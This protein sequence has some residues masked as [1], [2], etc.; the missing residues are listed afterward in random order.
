M[1]LIRKLNI[2]NNPKYHDPIKTGKN[3]TT[4]KYSE[5][6]MNRVKKILER[7][8][9]YVSEACDEYQIQLKLNKG[10]LKK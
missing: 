2:Q 9:N 4:H 10:K 8:P 5:A 1:C 7:Y 6:L 3:S